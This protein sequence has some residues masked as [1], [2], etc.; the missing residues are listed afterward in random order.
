MAVEPLPVV[1]VDSVYFLPETLEREFAIIDLEQ[2]VEEVGITDPVPDVLDGHTT[3][4]N[5]REVLS[6]LSDD[7]SSFDPQIHTTDSPATF[8]PDSRQSL[9]G[10]S[11]SSNLRLRLDFSGCDEDVCALHGVVRAWQSGADID[12]LS[13]LIGDR[14]T[15][16]I[17]IGQAE[18][19][20]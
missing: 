20:R 18:L 12:N 11:H 19:K 9:K 3:R 5:V 10:K 8:V 15:C 16:E 13:T 2:A 1:E 6:L 17:K 14:L 7:W 4:R